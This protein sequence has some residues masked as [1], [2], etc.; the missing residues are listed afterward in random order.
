MRRV[1]AATNKIKA[2][3]E[4]PDAGTEQPVQYK[5]VFVPKIDDQLEVAN[6]ITQKSADMAVITAVI[7]SRIV[8]LICMISLLIYSP[9]D[10]ND[11]N[12]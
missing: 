3:I 4:R 11:G 8:S 7:I 10:V 12:K 2:T 5:P 6:A 1:V 9:T